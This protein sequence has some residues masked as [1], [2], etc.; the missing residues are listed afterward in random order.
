VQ[1]VIP[2]PGHGAMRLTTARYYTPSG[3]SIQAEGI[4]PDIVVEP[5]DVTAIKQSRRTRE[6]DLKGALDSTDKKKGKKD[7]AND[8]EQEKPVDYQLSR[9]IDLLRGMTLYEDRFRESMNKPVA[10]DNT[11]DE[12]EA[13][14]PKS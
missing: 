1:T 14:K 4:T 8:N 12:K 10:N 3:R 5:A 7:A 11:N 13:A 2:I 9:A 6:S